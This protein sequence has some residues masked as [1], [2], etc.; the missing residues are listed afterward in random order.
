MSPTPSSIRDQL[1]SAIKLKDLDSLE[2]AIEEAEAI[3]YPE[4]GSDIRKARETFASLGGEA[5]G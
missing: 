3:G 4:L 5:R 1:R 2:A